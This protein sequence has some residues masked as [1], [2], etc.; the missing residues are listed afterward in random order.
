M[1]DGDGE[2]IGGVVGPRQLG[3]RE[4]RLHHPRDLILGG[5][6]IAADRRL[7]ALGRV[8][9]TRQAALA[10]G[11]HRDATSVTDGEGGL[12]VR[13]EVKL[14]ECHDIAGVLVDQLRTR[15]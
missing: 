14:L 4:Q 11:K 2:R 10:G 6:A 3:Q 7:D 9:E 5:A 13:P 12:D 1:T 8:G 15:S